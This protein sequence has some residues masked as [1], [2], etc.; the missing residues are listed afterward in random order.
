MKA[1]KIKD[2]VFWL[3][4]IDWDRRL[5]DSLVPLPNGTS[6]N[7][8]LV[9]GT[10][11]TALLDTVDPCAVDTLMS[12]LE[13]VPN[14]DYVVVHHAE[15]DH[16]GTLPRVLD[17]YRS[18]KVVTNPNCKRLLTD[19]LEVPEDRFMMV[20]DGQVLPLGGKTLKFVYTPWVHWP[21]TMVSYL[22]ED[23]MLFTCD[24][25]GSHL[26]TSDLYAVDEAHVYEAAKVY[27][28]MIMMPFRAAVEKNLE[29]LKPYDIG[30]IAPSHGPVYNKPSLVLDAYQDWVSGP[31]KNLVVLPYVSMHDSTRIMV[32]HL[33]DALAQRDVRVQQFNLAVTD[34]G[35]LA[36][37]LV[38]AATIVIGTPTVMANPHPSVV[39]ATYLT[40]AVKPK[41]KFAAVI[42]SYSWGSKVVEQI[43]A[44][45]PNLKLEALPS[46]ICKGLPRE[47]D[48]NAL[49]A[50]ADAIAEKHRALG[51]K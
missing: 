36:V 22:Q 44:M 2:G 35:K 32:M 51:F 19:L 46:V 38:D 3:G 15:Q 23:R 37:T 28:G 12:Q 11:K 16:S 10:E 29:K 25:F 4:Y 24:L 13:G 40:N 20:E 31:P 42:G 21:E 41:L 17:K 18:A 26:A 5:F 48:L 30:M 33:V 6:Y 1:R 9:Q 14:I 43:G 39:Y 27:Y 47:A 49:D 45:L 34:L 8:Y 7:A 50:L